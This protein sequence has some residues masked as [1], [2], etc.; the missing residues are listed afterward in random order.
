MSRIGK[1]PIPVPG[2]V[3]I[4]IDGRTIAVKGPKGSLSRQLPGE[5]TVSASIRT[6]PRF[7]KSATSW[8]G[9]ERYSVRVPI[10]PNRKGDAFGPLTHLERRPEPIGRAAAPLTAAAIM[11]Q[12]ANAGRSAGKPMTTRREWTRL[13]SPSWPR[14]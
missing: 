13:R 11:P 12:R 8:S 10:E 9:S 3:E 1:A 14:P 2:G 5:I 7:P 6:S 4:N